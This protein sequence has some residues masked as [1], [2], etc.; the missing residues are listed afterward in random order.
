MQQLEPNSTAA[1]F[2]PPAQRTHVLEHMNSDHGDAVLRYARFYAGHSGAT[3]AR[4]VGIDAQGIE[5]LVT[6]PA[7]ESAARINFETPLQQPDDAHLTL[8]A[9]AQEARRRETLA[10]ARE[11][12][13]WFRAEFK[14]VLLGTVSTE[15]VPEVSVAPAVL[16]N[17]GAF[18]V[19][20]STM[21][22]HTRNLLS[23]RRASVMLIED[24]AASAQLLARRRLTFP[25]TADAVS[26]DHPRFPHVMA[27]L[28]TKFGDVM[29]HLETMTDFHLIRIMPSAGRLVVGFGQAYTVDP[30]DWT[31]V[32]PV[33][34]GGHASRPAAK[35]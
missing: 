25:G 35:A 32:T 14:T 10:C 28:K 2:F 15:G 33:G 6:S 13:E 7:G 5:L 26:R 11:T 19:Y 8:V 30:L 20:V 9:M 27:Q 18:Y 3:A 21:A 24:E 34:G 22:A 31:Q 16:G 1:D 23:T 29:E 12:A 17:E 4:L